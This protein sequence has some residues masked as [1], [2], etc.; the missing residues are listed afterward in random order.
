MMEENVEIV[1]TTAKS[2]KI[3]VISKETVHHIC[4]GQVVLDLAVAIKELVE[5]SADSGANCIDV[6]LV[7]YGKTSIT[8]SDNGSGVLEHDFEGLGLKH[9]T[10]KL[11]DF[12]DLLEVSTFGFRGEAL[13]SLCSLSD[14][15]ITTK[16]L[17]NEHAYKLQFDRNG[18]LENKE[19][20]ARERGTTVCVKNIFKSL[21]V[22]IKEF[23]KNLKREFSKAIQILYGYCLVS[24]GIKITCTNKVDKKSEAS[25]VATNGADNVL[26]NAYCIF[27]KKNLNGI[28]IVDIIT[29]DQSIREEFHLPED[30]SVDFSWEFY[31][32]SCEHSMGRGS[33]DRQFFFV[34]GRPCNLTKISKLINNLYHKYNNK[35][36]PFVYLNLKLNQQ[37]ADVNVTPD[38]RTIFL[39]QEKLIFGTIKMSLQTKWDKMQGNFTEQALTQLQVSFKRN[40]VRNSSTSPPSKKLQLSLNDLNENKNNN[41][42]EYNRIENEFVR[43]EIDVTKLKK[44]PDREIKIDIESVVAAAEL[45]TKRQEN[46]DLEY[47]IKFRA[48]IDVAKNNDA[49]EELKKQLTKENFMEMKIIGQFNLGFIITQLDGDLFLIDQHASDEKFRFEK[50]NSE[51]KLKTQKLVIPKPLNLT[52]VN[53]TILLEHQEFF[54]ANGFSFDVNEDD[55]VG[56]RI[57]LIGMPVSGYWQFGQ[58]DIE[59]LIFLIKEG[60][61]EGVNSNLLEGKILRPSRIRQM[62]ASRACRSAV[63]IG[64]AL[65]TSEMQRLLTQMSQ[66]Q[67]PWNCPHGRPTIRHLL[68]LNLLH[69]S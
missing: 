5:N 25:I 53:E 43:Q 54:H 48:E 12:S 29:P 10:S 39:L 14:V 60:D 8:V 49:E 51:T 55:Q 7:D 59:E 2:K 61:P 15:T 69:N 50:L 65:N 6:K 27:G 31:V 66:M 24:T 62:L 52:A 64:T 68:S 32:S 36:Y 19:I 56:K 42:E 3:N 28:S 47:K 41:N 9:H 23:E 40:L 33:P 38:K 26:D 37:S 16:H 30:L 46:K 1:A 4:S 17:E 21:P 13:S 35:Q 44:L 45:K 20:C 11:R 18:R 63:M 58:T 34:N 57:K 22:R 67:N